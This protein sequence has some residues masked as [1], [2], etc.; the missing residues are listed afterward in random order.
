MQ[1]FPIVG[2]EPPADAAGVGEMVKGAVESGARMVSIPCAP[3]MH[4]TGCWLGWFIPMSAGGE[5]VTLART[6]PRP[7][8][9]PADGRGPQGRP[10]SRSSATASPSRS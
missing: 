1:G 8:R 4:G 3:L 9:G 10:C 2:L 5:I 7:A 6:Q